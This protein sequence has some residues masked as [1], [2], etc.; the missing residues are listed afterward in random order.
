MSLCIHDEHYSFMHVFC[1]L[2]FCVLQTT[3]A[4]CDLFQLFTPAT[5][6]RKPPCA[7]SRVTPQNAPAQDYERDNVLELYVHYTTALL[8]FLGFFTL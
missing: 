4:T 7:R 6:P 8:L 3:I 2:R 5:A 1:F